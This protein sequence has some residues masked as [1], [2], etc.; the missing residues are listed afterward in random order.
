MCNS[1]DNKGGHPNRFE[2]NITHDN[3]IKNLIARKGD[4]YIMQKSIREKRFRR[5][6]TPHFPVKKK[7]KSGL[8]SFCQQ[9]LDLLL[10]IRN[11]LILIDWCN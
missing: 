4:P 10:I 11:H 2:L 9:H 6:L 8:G 1:Q 7:D 3:H 5:L